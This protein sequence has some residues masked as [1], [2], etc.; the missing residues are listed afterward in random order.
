[1]CPLKLKEDERNP[2]KND[3]RSRWPTLCNSARLREEEQEDEEEV[4]EERQ[5]RKFFKHPLGNQK[6]RTD[7][8][9]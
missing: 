8:V 2:T 5:D 6:D 7:C 9:H 4:D 3:V 1:M